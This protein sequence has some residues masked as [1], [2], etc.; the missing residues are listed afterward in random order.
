M[1][2]GPLLSLVLGCVRVCV[3]VSVCACVCVCVCVCVC[4]AVCVVLFVC[5]GHQ[6]L[7]RNCRQAASEERVA[8]VRR[9][10]AVQVY[11]SASQIG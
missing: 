7:I 10:S 1:P 9:L 4:S 2:L 8:S 11:G 3:C 6:T 5:M